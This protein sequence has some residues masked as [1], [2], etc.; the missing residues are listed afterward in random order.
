M[1][2]QWYIFICKIFPLNLRA[3]LLLIAICTLIVIVFNNFDPVIV[4]V[5]YVFS[6]GEASELWVHPCCPSRSGTASFRVPETSAQPLSW[7]RDEVL[8]KS[9]RPWTAS[10]EMPLP[11]KDQGWG[12]P[13]PS[14]QEWAPQ[15]RR[16]AH[17]APPVHVGVDEA[18]SV[19]WS[20]EAN[21]RAAWFPLLGPQWHRSASLVVAL[22]QI[23]SDSRG[24]S[25]P[26]RH[27]RSGGGFQIGL[28]VTRMRPI[29]SRQV[30]PMAMITW[31][32]D[33]GSCITFQHS[34]IVP[35][36]SVAMVLETQIKAFQDYDRRSAISLCKQ[37]ISFESVCDLYDM[38]GTGPAKDSVCKVP[39][40]WIQVFTREYLLWPPT[41][42]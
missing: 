6:I 16:S 7:Q 8:V 12:C 22:G 32:S 15:V 33:K 14:I 10:V 27:C 26:S 3:I 1:S 25:G 5:T 41:I 17:K 19:R 35:C 24:V 11:L 34:S 9:A 4:N 18:A 23:A 20:L 31:R 42:F 39:A 37:L 38:A 36:C 28:T 2:T 21:S 13:P 30:R 40:N 29:T